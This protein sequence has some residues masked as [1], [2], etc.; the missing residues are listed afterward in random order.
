MGWPT[1]LAIPGL[2]YISRAWLLKKYVYAPIEPYACCCMFGRIHGAA[3]TIVVLAPLLCYL[4][5]R[6][7]ISFIRNHTS[8]L[9]QSHLSAT[10]HNRKPSVYDSVCIFCEKK[11]SIWTGNEAQD[12]L[13]QVSLSDVGSD[14]RQYLTKLWPVLLQQC[15]LLTGQGGTFTTSMIVAWAISW[16][17]LTVCFHHSDY[18]V[19][20][21]HKLTLAK[22]NVI[23]PP[24]TRP[25]S[26][27]A[28]WAVYNSADTMVK[29]R[30]SRTSWNKFR[31]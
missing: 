5:S 18:S 28:I 8:P 14:D 1:A 29:H 25:R 16:R 30:R 7:L 10:G 19:I 12:N 2:N 9:S 20:S 13:S 17:P 23:T 4:L 27:G 11:N 26:N 22:R 3:W 24:T 21:T 6:S 15:L 31:T